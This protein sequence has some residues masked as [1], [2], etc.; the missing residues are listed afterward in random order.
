MPNLARLLE[1]SDEE[2]RSIDP[3]LQNLAVAAEI[4]PSTEID[5]ESAVRTVDRWAEGCVRWMAGLE[6]H[7]HGDPGQWDGDAHFFRLGLLYQY[8]DQYL[9]IRYREDQ[10]SSSSVS[11]T[12]CSDLFVHGVVETH[13]GTC[14]NLP[15]TYAAL[16]WRL[17]IPVTLACIGYHVICQYSGPTT[18]Y[19]LEITGLGEGGFSTPS[20]S[21]YRSRPYFRPSAFDEGSDLRP[22]TPRE[23]VG[24]YLLARARHHRDSGRIT[25]MLGDLRLVERLYPTSWMRRDLERFSRLLDDGRMSMPDQVPEKELPDFWSIPIA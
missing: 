12:D 1:M 22:L 24:F 7:F 4:S 3:V 14:G 16:A 5:V 8:M 9:G 17:D 11:Y 2:L 13:R 20:D 19:N 6:H 21:F 15:A 18:R 25:A 23:T 10:R